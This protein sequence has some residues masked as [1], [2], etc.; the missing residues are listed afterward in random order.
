MGPQSCLLGDKVY[1]ENA[2][3]KYDECT[4]CV[5]QVSGKDSGVTIRQICDHLG[6]T[7]NS[8]NI[9]HRQTCPSL[10][11]EQ[12]KQIKADGECCPS[13][14]LASTAKQMETCHYKNRIYKVKSQFIVIDH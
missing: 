11:C 12:S 7:Q 9:C 8:T 13:C 3:F 10:Q 6:Y 2:K 4:S 1:R 14:A 5:C